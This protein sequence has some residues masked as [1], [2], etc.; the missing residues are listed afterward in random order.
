[1]WQGGRRCI[2]HHRCWNEVLTTS[3]SRNRK[4]EQGKIK[5]SMIAN[6]WEHAPAVLKTSNLIAVKAISYKDMVLLPG[7][8]RREEHD[9][10]HAEPQ[11]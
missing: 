10:D 6:I 3:L 11:P 4:N 7:W 9:H 8:E 2:A 5:A 1:M